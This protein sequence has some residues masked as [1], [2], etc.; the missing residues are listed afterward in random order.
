MSTG[1]GLSQHDRY[2]RESDRDTAARKVRQSFGGPLDTLT[3]NHLDGVWKVKEIDTINVE[4]LF[5]HDLNAQVNKTS[6]LHPN[7][8]WIA[9][10][11]HDGDGSAFG[12]NL[13]Y[14][15]GDTISAN[16]IGLRLKAVGRTIGSDNPV[17]AAVWFQKVEIPW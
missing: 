8:I 1:T 4:I 5:R 12:M 3:V 9:V 16:E 15:E 14:Q 7:V 17:T 13:E 2:I 11:R 6:N 10:F